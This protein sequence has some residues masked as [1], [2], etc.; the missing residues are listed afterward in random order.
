MGA[1]RNEI[2]LEWDHAAEV[3][4][5]PVMRAAT[6]PDREPL[7]DPLFE[8]ALVTRRVADEWD[9]PTRELPADWQALLRQQ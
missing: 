5:R 9:E 8:Q 2:A 4:T 6:A 3:T 7:T 1:A